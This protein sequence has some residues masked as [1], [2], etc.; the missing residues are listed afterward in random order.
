MKP[1]ARTEPDS[2]STTPS[3]WWPNAPLP[4]TRCSRPTPTLSWPPGSSRSQAQR[5]TWP[6]SGAGWRS[7]PR[8]AS[9]IK[10]LFHVDALIAVDE[11]PGGLAVPETGVDRDVLHHDLV[12]VEREQ[13]E[14]QRSR[15]PLGEFH[16]LPP[17]PASLRGRSHGDVLDQ[18][19]VA[20]GDEHDDADGQFAALAWLARLAWLAGL[21]WFASL[22]DQPGHTCLDFRRVV[23]DDRC[24][25]PVHPV[26]VDGI[27]RGVQSLN[28]RQ[29]A[30]R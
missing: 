22:A 30:D 29:V 28:R 1:G 13:A 7:R 26:T 21:A 17:K 27:R 2:T 19:A 5:R 4:V 16:Q 12:R 6:G 11:A 23:V 3:L 15:L 10:A 8:L 14:P 18:Q 25:R 24:G 9:R 20:G